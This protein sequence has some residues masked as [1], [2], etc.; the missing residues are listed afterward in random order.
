MRRPAFTLVEVLLT[1]AVIGLIIAFL[2]PD[3]SVAMRVRSM[4][5][6]A[7]RLRSLVVMAR[8]RSM[9]DGLQYRIEFPGTPDPLDRFAEKEVDVPMETLQ[10]I[11]KRQNKPQEAPDSYE[12]VHEHWTDQ[13]FLRPG[14]RCVAALA[15]KPNFDIHPDSPIAGPKVTEG[16]SEFVGLTF[17]PDGTCDWVTFVLT[18]LPYEVEPKAEDAVRIF[19]VIVD[20][21]TGQSWMQRAFRTEEVE[22]MNEYGASPILHMDF[23]DPALITE[24]NILQIRLGPTGATT[25]RR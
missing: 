18:D 6:S 23:I 20:G 15:G 16:R 5:D 17:Y 9:K 13:E 1:I 19:N 2:Y 3:L 4:E 22:T 25:G 10:P 24:D 14:V 11:T 7:D 8:S 21:R 12:D